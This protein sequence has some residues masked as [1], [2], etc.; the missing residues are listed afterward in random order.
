MKLIIDIDEENTNG[1]RRIIQ[2]QTQILLLEQSQMTYLM[3]K[4]CIV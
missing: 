4:T 3:K 2:T 1:L